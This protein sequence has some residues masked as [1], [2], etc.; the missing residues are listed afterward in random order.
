M[1]WPMAKD[2]TVAAAIQRYFLIFLWWLVC[3][4]DESPYLI[5][6]SEYSL[7]GRDTILGLEILQDWTRADELKA[8]AWAVGQPG[9]LHWTGEYEDNVRSKGV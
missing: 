1:V 3:E 8:G 7:L 5:K 2:K 9:R 4:N 6:V